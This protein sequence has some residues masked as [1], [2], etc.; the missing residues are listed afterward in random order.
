MGRRLA[1]V[2]YAHK[3]AKLKSPHRDE[4]VI[5]VLAGIRWTLGTAGTP[6]SALTADLVARLLAECPK[7]TLGGLRDRALIALGFAGAFRRSE[8][9]ALVVSDLETTD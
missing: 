8:L 7:H 4:E 3:L 2:A 5:E 9:V 6:K 1:A